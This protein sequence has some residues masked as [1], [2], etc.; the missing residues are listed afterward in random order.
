MTPQQRP[1]KLYMVS[2]R[3]VVVCTVLVDA[4]SKKEA[5]ALVRDGEGDKVGFD[6]DD[7][8]QRTR[9]E[10]RLDATEQS[11]ALVTLRDVREGAGS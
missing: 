1:S 6:V 9:F 4:S 8:V 11:E 2:Y 7:T 5:I 3:E 10:A